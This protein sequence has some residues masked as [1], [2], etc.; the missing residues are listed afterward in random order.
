MGKVVSLCLGCDVTLCVRGAILACVP[1]PISTL[2]HLPLLTEVVLLALFLFRQLH[3]K[4][5]RAIGAFLSVWHG[6]SEELRGE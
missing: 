6:V 4:F 5:L 2:R 3:R 1:A